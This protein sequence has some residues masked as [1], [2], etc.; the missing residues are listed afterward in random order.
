MALGTTAIQNAR[1]SLNVIKKN[2]DAAST[3]NR[4]FIN[5]FNDANFQKFVKETNKGKTL[6]DQLKALSDW[7]TSLES[8]VQSLD[9]KTSKYL[10]TQDSLNG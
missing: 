4:E 10:S 5:L 2:L 6:N 3:S 1:D 7:L 8:V 9:E